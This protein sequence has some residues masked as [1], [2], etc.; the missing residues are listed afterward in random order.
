MTIKLKLRMSH[1]RT[2]FQNRAYRNVPNQVASTMGGFTSEVLLTMPAFSTSSTFLTVDYLVDLL[3]VLPNLRGGRPPLPG[4]TTTT[5]STGAHALILSLP[6]RKSL[7]V[8]IK[9]DGCIATKELLC[10]CS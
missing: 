3:E 1:G 6:L 5:G 8:C 10:I 4:S 9:V 2:T 7:D